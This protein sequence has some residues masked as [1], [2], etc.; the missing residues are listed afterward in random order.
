MNSK[1]KLIKFRLKFRLIHF[2]LIVASV[3]FGLWYATQF[4]KRRCTAVVDSYRLV[5]GDDPYV[6][7]QFHFEEPEELKGERWN[8]LIRDIPV[9][10]F[11]RQI[12]SGEHFKFQY[13]AES[14]LLE[15][16]EDA[17]MKLW[18]VLLLNETSVPRD[19][20]EDFF[21]QVSREISANR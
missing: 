8:L 12:E 5:D 14:T 11:P 21:S 19:I 7:M 10:C 9:A 18:K 4:N 15:R 17:V 16:K 13:Q 6:R 1:W 2:F 3:A 20:I